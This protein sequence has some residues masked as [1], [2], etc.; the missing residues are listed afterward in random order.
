VVETTVILCR[1]GNENLMSTTA[2][3]ASPRRL[4]RN[5][6]LTTVVVAL[7]AAVFFGGSALWQK[8]FGHSQS[9][10]ADCRQAQKVIDTAQTIPAGKAA[11]DASYTAYRAEWSKIDDGYLQGN[12]ANY[13]Y[14]AYELAEGRALEQTP[15]EFAE[16]VELANSHCEQ[17]IVMPAHPPI[18]TP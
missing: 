7:L 1:T 17:T 4:A 11:R 3:G 12:V 5:V 6:V 9:S 16:M 15:A 8:Q 14:G 18:A 10:A 13:V 2:L